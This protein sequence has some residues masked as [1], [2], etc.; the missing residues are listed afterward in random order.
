MKVK[1]KIDFFNN[2]MVILKYDVWVK[3]NVRQ[4]EF[5][6]FVF[7]FYRKELDVGVFLV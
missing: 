5:Y 7:D 3:M 4:D 2:K 6:L 1:E